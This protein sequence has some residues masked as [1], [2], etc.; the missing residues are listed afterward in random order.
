M[1]SCFFHHFFTRIPIKV[2]GVILQSRTM[3]SMV[4]WMVV[5]GGGRSSGRGPAHLHKPTTKT[6]CLWPLSAAC[7]CANSTGNRYHLHK[8]LPVNFPTP[9]NFNREASASR[10]STSGKKSFCNVS[11]TVKVI[12]RTGVLTRC[13]VAN[14]SAETSGAL[15]LVSAVSQNS[16]GKPCCTT[17]AYI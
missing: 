6:P 15:L 4:M 1:S 11:S 2:L 8:E 12:A 3:L 5:G 13:V 17:T 7:S 14:E 16:Y 9:R 10:Q